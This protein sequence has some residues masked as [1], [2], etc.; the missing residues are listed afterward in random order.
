MKKIIS[1]IILFLFLGLGACKSHKSGTT[2]SAYDTDEL[3]SKA[4]KH[5]GTRY[6]SGG[7]EPSKGFD[8]S[9]YTRY[10]FGKFN[11]NLPA[12][13]VQQSETGRAVLLSEANKGDLIFFKGGD[14]KI[15]TV[16]HVGIIVS[17]RGGSVKFI[18]ASSS[19]GIMIS[20]LDEKY[21]RERFVRIRRVK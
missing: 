21:F 1:I 13:A 6:K 19:K 9:G 20:S 18:H 8:C 12:T 16:G 17:G 4:K 10:M 3:V 11:I 14:A 15:K 2:S 7:S 5:I